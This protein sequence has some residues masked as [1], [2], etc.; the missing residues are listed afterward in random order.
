MLRVMP[1]VGGRGYLYSPN[2]DGCWWWGRGD[3]MG[4]SGDVR[5]EVGRFCMIAA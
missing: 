4:E 1:G 5:C 2:Q 3:G